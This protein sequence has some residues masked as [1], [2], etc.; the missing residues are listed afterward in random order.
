MHGVPEHV[1]LRDTMRMLWQ[2]RQTRRGRLLFAYVL[3]TWTALF[4]A[5]W[6]F[7]GVLVAVIVGAAL[8]VVTLGIWHALH[9][10]GVR[11]DGHAR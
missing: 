1:T 11:F 7:N 5:N 9:R 6:V 3:M 10:R 8:I 2:A 4:A